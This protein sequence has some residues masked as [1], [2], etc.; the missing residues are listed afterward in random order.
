[1]EGC[2]GELLGTWENATRDQYQ[3]SDIPGQG[4][5]WP[6]LR[7]ALQGWWPGVNSSAFYI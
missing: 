1:M 3:V 2:L 7:G 4:D 6:E 5:I